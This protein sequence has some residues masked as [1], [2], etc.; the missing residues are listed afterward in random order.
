MAKA[1]KSIPAVKRRELDRAVEIL[2]ESFAEAVSTR[3]A[4]RLKNGRILKIIL[5]GSYARGDWVDD[6]IGRY[7]SDF[8]LMVVVD[9]DDLTDSDFWRAAEQRLLSATVAGQNLRTPVS[10]IVHSLDDVNHR[11]ERGRYFF[12]DIVRDGVVLFDTPGVD[13]VEPKALAAADA[14]E[15]ARGYFEDWMESASG[16]MRIADFCIDD[17]RLKLA[18]FNLHQASEHL[19]HCL[20]LVM[21]LYAPKSHKLIAL[22]KLAEPLLPELAEVWPGQTKFERRAFELL[23]AAYVKARYSRH[24]KIT[25]EELEWLTSRI[26]LLREIVREACEAHITELANEADAGLC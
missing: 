18:A 14:L 19:Y 12:I 9:H 24:Y 23:R 5:F 11:L 4:E 22:R 20:M 21:T 3:E 2:R 6:P 15:E 10:V 17:N 13:F 1:L 16:F 26:E 25:R 7:F 8:D